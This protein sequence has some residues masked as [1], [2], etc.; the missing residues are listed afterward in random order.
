MEAIF[1]KT[2]LFWVSCCLWFLGFASAT[3]ANAVDGE[4]V[5]EGYVFDNNTLQPL[6]NA[7]VIVQAKRVTAADP[8]EIV[9]T[10]LTDRNGF[11]Y[12]SFDMPA[13]GGVTVVARCYSSGR[14][15]SAQ[16][17]L[18]LPLNTQHAYSRNLYLKLP[19]GITS[20]RIQ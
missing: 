8:V 7:S 1:N 6:R 9:T 16:S 18:I 12:G 13:A 17:D 14:L 4:Y 20:C 11:F 19:R 15:T 5:L 3:A 10:Y 2:F